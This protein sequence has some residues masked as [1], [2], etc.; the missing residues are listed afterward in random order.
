MQKRIIAVAI[1]L[2]GIALLVLNTDNVF[3]SPELKSAIKSSFTKE[4]TLEG[5]EKVIEEPDLRGEDFGEL[6]GLVVPECPYDFNNDGVV[7]DADDSEMQSRNMCLVAQNLCCNLYDL[8]NDGVV[9]NGDRDLLQNYYGLCPG[10]PVLEGACTPR[11]IRDG[12]NYRSINGG[13][14]NPEWVWMI[15]NLNQNQ[16][17]GVYSAIDISGP[18]IGVA[19]GNEIIKEIEPYDGTFDF[20]ENTI[21]LPNNY[22]SLSLLFYQPSD[23][24]NPE[25]REYPLETSIKRE[26]MDTTQFV[27]VPQE[28]QQY[29]STTSQVLT[30]STDVL[31]TESQFHGKV[32]AI[33]TTANMFFDIVGDYYGFSIRIQGDATYTYSLENVNED[34]SVDFRVDRWTSGHQEYG[35]E[36]INVPFGEEFVTR[37][38]KIK[39]QASDFSEDFTHHE[40]AAYSV[41]NQ[42]Q[43]FDAKLPSAKMVMV[44]TPLPPVINATPTTRPLLLFYENPETG[45]LIFHSVIYL[46]PNDNPVFG[47]PRIDYGYM[48]HRFQYSLSTLFHDYGEFFFGM[49]STYYRGPHLTTERFTTK[50]LLNSQGGIISLGNEQNVAEG[51]ELDYDGIFTTTNNP[52]DIYSPSEHLGD[53]NFD[54]RSNSVVVKDPAQHSLNEEVTFSLHR[55]P[56]TSTLIL[57]R[58]NELGTLLNT[59]LWRHL[60]IGYP[61]SS[62]ISDVYVTTYYGTLFPQIITPEFVERTYE[63]NPYIDVRNP[64][65]LSEEEVL[66]EYSMC[67]KVDAHEAIVFGG[68]N[69]KVTTALITGFTEELEPEKIYFASEKGYRNEDQEIILTIE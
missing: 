23:G 39:I 47:N 25:F 29:L 24:E 7:D 17:T 50:Y 44:L 41:V 58:F 31:E 37:G 62:P 46:H 45:Q 67:G 36:H 12:D 55:K 61:L 42:N 33:M 1:V 20:F 53:K 22:Q 32:P 65:G 18:V 2:V 49:E 48:T 3:F 43:Q 63:T 11:E 68:E 14:E 34:L 66:V 26:I 38:K 13:Q 60:D 10:R 64:L 27:G 30:L 57:R 16:K 8:N 19:N 6:C 5:K 4:A 40:W 69:P 52:G 54:M 21:N 9:N 59:P 35:F 51:S 56:F 28:Y 15:K